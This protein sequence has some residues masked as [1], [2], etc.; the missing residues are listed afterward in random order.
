MNFRR[1]INFWP[2]GVAAI[3]EKWAKL[4]IP[5][6]GTFFSDKVSAWYNIFRFYHSF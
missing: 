1:F 6:H 4:T 5:N 3:M 2:L